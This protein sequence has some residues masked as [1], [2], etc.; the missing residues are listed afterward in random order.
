MRKRK[1]TR[2]EGDGDKTWPSTKL[3]VEDDETTRSF[4]WAVF[5]TCERGTKTAIRFGADD[6]ESSFNGYFLVK[7][8]E[9]TKWDLR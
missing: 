7:M 9:Y 5:Q 4:T 1:L 3:L 2:I 6:H 8:P